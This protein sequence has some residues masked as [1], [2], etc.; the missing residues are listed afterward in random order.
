MQT[1]DLDQLRSFLAV[2]ETSSFTRAADAVA[3]TQS[4]VSMQIK[5]LEETIGKQLFIRE[6]R[7]V[8]LSV[9]GA[10]LVPY[11]RDLVEKSSEALAAFDETA[12]RGN[13]YLGTADD[14]AER[15]LPPILAGFSQ[16]NPLVEVSVVCENT[17]GLSKRVKS[18]ELDMAVI[19]H[20]EVR[21]HSELIRTEPLQWV[22][23]PGH[24]VHLQRPLPLALGSPQCIWRKQALE[25][26][27][28]S[29][30]RHRML[31]SSYS[32]TVLGAAVM[33]GL[34]VAV[35]PESAV[36]PGMRVLGE[37]EGF[38]ELSECQIG[39][40]RG[41]RDKSDVT[42]ALARHI[43]QSLNS[44]GNFDMSYIN[45]VMDPFNSTGPDRPNFA[46]QQKAH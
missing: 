1:L 36:R 31:Y 42:E 43:R 32:A 5:K 4:A 30:V 35:L 39:L 24:I 3:K 37:K 12:L 33:S 23:S 46:Y 40:L 13:V 11:A 25:A 22:T 29:G 34:A 17:S 45:Q 27:T 44:M 15:F 10:R 41:S 14:Y 38:P 8:S 2:C 21:A 20:N 28:R 19:T 9:D 26:L 7:C 6:K 16:S 18:G